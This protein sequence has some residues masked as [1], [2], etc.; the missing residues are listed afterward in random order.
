[1]KKIFFIIIFLSIFFIA[2]K[3]ASATCTWRTETTISNPE[4][5]T[6]QISGGCFTGETVP[7]SSSPEKCLDTKPAGSGSGF[8]TSRSICCCSAVITNTAPE[9]PKF[10]IPEFQIKI[11][12]M[13]KL[14]KVDCAPG[15]GGGYSC[16]IPWIGEYIIGFY[17]YALAVAGILAAM[18]MLAGGVFWLIS[19]GDATK[20][21]TAKE[22]IGGSITG[23]IILSISYLLLNVVNPDLT[24]IKPIIVDT[25]KDPEPISNAGNP[26]NSTACNNCVSLP[27]SIQY[28]NGNM[29]NSDFNA[30]L[31]I[32][33]SNSTLSWMVTEAYP[34]SSKHNSTCHYNGMCVDIA[35]TAA[36]NCADVS[37]LITSLQKAGLSVFNEY[38]D[39][40]GKKT[41]YSTGG[42]L[43]VY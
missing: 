15:T 7:N 37:N 11:P 24:K 2:D 36:A 17:D 9:M 30:K 4:L 1:M 33:R 39:C 26:N 21:T 35:L 20:V 32:G 28:K 41:Q 43:H 19:G 16:E 38:T 23:I 27:A 18:V 10:E 34:P 3:Q 14:S 6:S 25:I 22:L 13:K 40:N 31:I 8:T 12:G 42:H 29:I 5:G